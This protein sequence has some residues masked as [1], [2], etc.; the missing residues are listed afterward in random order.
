MC[1]VFSVHIRIRIRV[2]VLLDSLERG[3]DRVLRVLGIN[4]VNRVRS[5][6]FCLIWVD[7]IIGRWHDGRSRDRPRSLPSAPEDKMY[8]KKQLHEEG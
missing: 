7:G 6:V 2:C 4:R 3:V 8:E 1:I 5:F